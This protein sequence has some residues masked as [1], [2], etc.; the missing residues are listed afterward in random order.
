MSFWQAPSDVPRSLSRSSIAY[1][2]IQTLILFF[3]ALNARIY[4]L[5]SM[6]LFFNARTYSL[7]FKPCTSA[8]SAQTSP[9]GVL[10]SGLA[11]RRPRL[12]LRPS[13]SSAQASPIGV[14]GS[15]LAPRRPRLRPR[16]SAPSTQ[17]SPIGVLGSGLALWRPRLGLRLTASSTQASHFGVLGS[18]LA[19][20]RI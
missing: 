10:D 5:F 17:T 13:A 12:R 4:S 18:G 15:G 14:L 6:I 9:I 16:T 2:V 11:H 7:Q 3:D 1:S 8:S 20:R 19:H